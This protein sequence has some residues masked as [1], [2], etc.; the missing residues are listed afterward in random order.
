MVE[1][2]REVTTRL[3]RAFAPG[4]LTAVF[5]PELDARD[6]RGRGSVGAGV[7]LELGARAV[8]R[9]TPGPRR[10]VRLRAD[11]PLPLPISTQVAERMLG[12]RRGRLTVELTHDLPVGQGF[13][14]SAAG[15]LA[16]AL[17]VGRLFGLPRRRAVE[18]AHLADLFGAGGLGGVAAILGGGME[19]RERAGVPPFGV[20][21]HRPFPLPMYVSVVGPP[22]ASPS[23]LT[24]PRFLERVRV[25][26]GESL[27]R[28]QER[29][30]PESLLEEAE[31][32]GKRLALAERPLERRLGRLRASGARAAQAMF[33][34]VIYAVAPGPGETAKLEE[35]LRRQGCPTLRLF[36]AQRGASVAGRPLPAKGP[37]QAF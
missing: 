15:A 16:T 30:T 3:A 22:I 35:E 13:G 33:G 21:R 27:P 14:M 12:D 34:R 4:H 5:R 32:F 36:G 17:A 7:T 8:A 26:S 9:F 23:L 28:L 31:R 19:L 1:A 10:I 18:T 25:A 20:V 24:S 37:R 6:P 29:F 11:L 2:R